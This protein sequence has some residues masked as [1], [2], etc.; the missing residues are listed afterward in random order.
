MADG[1]PH[2]PIVRVGRWTRL[3]RFCPVLPCSAVGLRYTV[4][5]QTWSGLGTH[6]RRWPP[7]CQARRLSR[8]QPTHELCEAGQSGQQR[9][10]LRHGVPPIRT[11]VRSLRCHGGFSLAPEPPRRVARRRRP[12]E[13]TYV[14]VRRP[15]EPR[16]ARGERAH[17]IDI[18]VTPDS[19][20]CTPR[21]AQLVVWVTDG[22]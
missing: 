18:Q 15:G 9:E 13:P 4:C 8:Q 22:Y 6:T 21:R 7:R 10:E 16:S 12:G 11:L 17:Q 3:I 20:V 1:T 2:I 14:P 19:S 5:V